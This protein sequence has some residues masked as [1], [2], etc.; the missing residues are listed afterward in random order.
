MWCSTVSSRK[1]WKEGKN[2]ETQTSLGPWH[3]CLWK[4]V[5]F[6]TDRCHD[7]LQNVSSGNSRNGTGDQEGGRLGQR[8]V[9][10]ELKETIRG[11]EVLRDDRSWC[12]QV[13]KAGTAAT[14]QVGW[15]C[16]WEGDSAFSCFTGG[17]HEGEDAFG[18]DPQWILCLRSGNG[19]VEG[20]LRPQLRF[21]LKHGWFLARG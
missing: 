4:W 12:L 21:H 16:V 9:C 14:S 7:M 19:D 18:P 2:Q 11:R 20:E 3:G 13:G 17:W 10:V 5:N 8:E 1:Y 6:Q 15:C